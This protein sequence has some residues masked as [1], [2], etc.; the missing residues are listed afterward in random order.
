ML[1]LLKKHF[2]Y[3]AP[4][5]PALGAW[6]FWGWESFVATASAEATMLTTI[7]LYTGIACTG[8][9]IG[10]IWAD[11]SR[12]NS[13]LRTWFSRRHSPIELSST[14][15]LAPDQTDCQSSQKIMY[16]GAVITNTTEKSVKDITIK[17]RVKTCNEQDEKEYCY[18]VS[19]LAGQEQIFVPCVEFLTNDDGSRSQYRV[20][21]DSNENGSE[22]C[23]YHKDLT[24]NLCL[25]S[26]VQP[27]NCEQEMR[28]S[29][30]QTNPNLRLGMKTV[31]FWDRFE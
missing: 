1:K 23:S 3:S 13:P 7:G 29:S 26:D 17:I 21:M 31:S 15:K 22:W 5:V 12:K 8:A 20:I 16:Y 2:R 27:I 30:P 10:V 6:S 24:V 18:E 14:R 9:I 19:R 28:L 11:A 25:A 4:G